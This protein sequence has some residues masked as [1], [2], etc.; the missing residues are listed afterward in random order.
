MR[1]TE[2]SKQ[3]IEQVRH[4]KIKRAFLH[5]LND[6]NSKEAKFHVKISILYFYANILQLVINEIKRARK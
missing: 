6:E 4:V 3:I 2:E 5:S 1:Y